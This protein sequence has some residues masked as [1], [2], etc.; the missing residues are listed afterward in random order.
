MASDSFSAHGSLTS[1]ILFSDT[2]T[3]HLLSLCI[4]FNQLLLDINIFP[5]TKAP[6][7]LSSYLYV[8]LYMQAFFAATTC[9]YDH[10]KFIFLLK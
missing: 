5:L 7:V 6:S 1:T 10:R 3:E 9:S 4:N 8:D 2:C